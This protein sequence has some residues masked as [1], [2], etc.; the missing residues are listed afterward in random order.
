M[1]LFLCKKYIMLQILHFGRS[2]TFRCMETMWNQL[3]F[4][5]NPTV[6]HPSTPERDDRN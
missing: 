1:L 2:S 6:C 3:N 5:S 4:H